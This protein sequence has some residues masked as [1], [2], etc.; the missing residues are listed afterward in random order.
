MFKQSRQL[1]IGLVVI[2][3]LMSLV[4]SAWLVVQVNLLGASD[5]ILRAVLAFALVFVPIVYGSYLWVKNPN[6]VL[7]EEEESD[8][9]Q[10]L[11]LLE[12]LPVKSPRSFA[13]L[14]QISQLDNQQVIKRLAELA[15]LRLFNGY[16]H[17]QAEQVCALSLQD[18][19]NLRVCVVCQR[20]LDALL[21]H[22]SPC[23]CAGCGTDYLMASE[24]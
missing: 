8:V 18:M 9:A 2:G 5:F 21:L 4:A 15:R 3:F 12:A 20:P 17:W 23:R 13:D 11:R 19:H 14:A 7:S 10:A 16:I 22:T 6:S 24:A 1:G